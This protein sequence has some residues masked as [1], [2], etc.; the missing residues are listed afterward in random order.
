MYI[1]H[2][3]NIYHYL[4]IFKN[5]Y[6]LLQNNKKYDI[7]VKHRKFIFNKLDLI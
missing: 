5:Y 7:L 1:K 3:L 2:I 4:W 6:K